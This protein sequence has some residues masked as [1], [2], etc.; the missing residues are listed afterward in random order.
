MHKVPRQ[1]MKVFAWKS[2]C[3]SLYPLLFAVIFIIHLQSFSS[4]FSATGTSHQM[5]GSSVKSIGRVTFVGNCPCL[6]C[7][8]YYFAFFSEIVSFFL[9]LLIFS[10]SKILIVLI[11]SYYSSAWNWVIELSLNWD[12]VSHMEIVKWCINQKVIF[13][14]NMTIS[15]SIDSFIELYSMQLL[16]PFVFVTF[17]Q[18][19]CSFSIQ[20]KWLPFKSRNSFLYITRFH[21]LITTNDLS[22]V[23]ILLGNNNPC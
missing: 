19:S 12:T 17:V 16:Y 8:A 5:T 1:Y 18:L 21:D 11:L 23:E 9:S 22:I 10:N 2:I 15:L 3:N 4:V 13:M 7:L 6:V 20:W 14:D